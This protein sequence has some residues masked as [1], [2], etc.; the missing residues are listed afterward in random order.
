MFKKNKKTYL[1]QQVAKMAI[2]L[3][4][5]IVIGQY[6]I[7][8]WSDHRSQ[9]RPT[10]LKD[11]FCILIGRKMKAASPIRVEINSLLKFV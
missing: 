10:L 9:N 5:R 7:G 11:S 2:T 3:V 4:R 6:L 1:N 8:I